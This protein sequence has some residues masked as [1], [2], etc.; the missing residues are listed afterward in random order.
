M[1]KRQNIQM[2][3]EFD[4]DINDFLNY[5]VEGELPILN[6]RGIVIFPA[7]FTS[8]IIARESTKQLIRDLYAQEKRELAVFAQKDPDLEEPAEGDLIREGAYARVVK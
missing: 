2:I 6:T 5:K 1:D 7:I 4:G 3:T 8:L